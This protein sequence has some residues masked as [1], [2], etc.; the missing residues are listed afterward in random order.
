M[1]AKRHFCGFCG[2]P[3]SYWSENPKS[4]AEF[5]SLTLGSLVGDDLR[6]L[7]ELGLLP[8]GGIGRVGG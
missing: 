6:D 5:I 7:D 8:E 1:D 3:L 4:E 2:T